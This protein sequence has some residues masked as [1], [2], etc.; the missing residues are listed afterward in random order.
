MPLAFK[1]CLVALSVGAIAVASNTWAETVNSN[2]VTHE[3]GRY[4][5]AMNVDMAADL[6]D[7]KNVLSDLKGF[8]RL[9]NSV[10]KST[11][12][13]VTGLAVG[14]QRMKAEI[15]M[16]ALFFCKHLTQIQD[17]HWASPFELRAKV[18]AAGSDFKFGEARWTLVKQSPGVTRMFF[19]ATL[20]PKFW[21]PP[22]IGPLV[23][24][25]KMLSEAVETSQAIESLANGKPVIAPS[26]TPK[27]I[28]PSK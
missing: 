6:S 26:R 2:K 22:L 24:E 8:H 27:L 21:I 15:S 28:R 16:C 19:S 13:P 4:H 23:I 3:N 17:M 7:V 1:P 10:K 5:I 12:L 11:L 20:E 18:I 14:T 9:N 25:R